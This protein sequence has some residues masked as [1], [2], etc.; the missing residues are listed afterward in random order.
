MR[1]PNA[2]RGVKKIW[3]AEL[4]MLLAVIVGI[5]LLI[6]VAANSTME[7]EQVVVNQEAVKTPVAILGISA[8]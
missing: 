3:V 4:L 8:A 6:V 2:F 7:G 5:V 1:F